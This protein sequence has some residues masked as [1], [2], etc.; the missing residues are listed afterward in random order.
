MNGAELITL[1]TALNGGVPMD[2]DVAYII[3]NMMRA[4]RE[5]SRDWVVLRSHDTSAVFTGSDDYEDTKPLPDRFIRIYS[6]YDPE[7]REQTGVFIVT[8]N[9][10]KQGLNPIPFAKRFDYKDTDGYYYIDLKN[11]AIGRTGTLAGTMHLYFLEGNVDID[12]TTPW[13]GFPSFASP[14]LAYDAVIEQKGGIDWDTVNANQVPF[15]AVTV[16]KL[17][18]E[19]NM[20]DA[21]LQQAEIGV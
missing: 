2:E 9:G 16:R 8:S 7:A 5:D 21:R 12:A 10:S 11:N 20:W 17:E 18:S 4:R 15:N 13:T 6:P 1:I 19:L 14:L 3:L